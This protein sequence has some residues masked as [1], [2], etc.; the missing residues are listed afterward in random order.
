[1]NYWF[2]NKSSSDLRRRDEELFKFS[3]SKKL[4]SK[5]NGDLGHICEIVLHLTLYGP[6]RLVKQSGGKVQKRSLMFEIF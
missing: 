1:M 6:R 2:D 4:F 3:K 5:V